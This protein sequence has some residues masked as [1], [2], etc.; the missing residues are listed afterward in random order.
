MAGRLGW[1]VALRLLFMT[2][3]FGLTGSFY[4]RS[5]FQ[6]G[7]YSNRVL[8]ASLLTAYAVS[9]VYLI[10]LRRRRYLVESAYVELVVDQAIWTSLI[11]VTGGATS[12]ATA[13]YGLTCLAGAILIGPR[14]PFVAAAAGAL[15]YFLLCAGFVAGV[16]DV[17]VDQARSSYVVD[18]GQILY[19]FFINLLVLI[20][21]TLLAEYLAERL[22]LAGGRLEEA[23]QRAEDAERLAALGRIAAG[24]AHE[25][26]NPLGSIV[27]SV[28]L[29]STAEGVGDE[30]RQLCRIVERETARLNDL[31]ED[32]LQLAR[33]RRPVLTE[34]DVARTAREVVSLASQSGRGSDVV[35]R[36]EGPSEQEML[37]TQAD[38]GQLRQVVWNL[39]RNAVQASSPGAKVIVRVAVDA[40]GPTARPPR[41]NEPASAPVLE[42]HDDGPGISEEARQRLFDA[43]F[44]TRSSG[45]GIGLAVVKR[46][47]DEHGWLIEVDSKEG[48]GA[49]FRVCMGTDAPTTI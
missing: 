7:T 16:I 12:G 28:Q 11:Y 9:G 39:V 42:V 23:T 2:V 31:V 15:F 34:V 21:V 29:L 20:I 30:G 47:V 27:G 45:I 22:R 25:I 33:P 4:L 13:L 37:V 3:L 46:I 44:T 38:A 6:L 24:L 40:C 48:R 43:F 26:R 49:T 35:V 41:A 14:G 10:G 5:G 36:Y 8:L 1:L 32:M 18:L 19:P 17:P